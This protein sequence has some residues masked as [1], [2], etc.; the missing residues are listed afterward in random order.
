MKDYISKILIALLIITNFA[1]IGGVV[2]KKKHPQTTPLVEVKPD[3]VS[4]LTPP[5]EPPPQPKIEPKFESYPAIRNITNLGKVLSDI[6]GHMPAGHIYK[7]ND[8]I[9]WAHETTHGINSNIRQKFAS[10]YAD[11]TLYG[12]WRP[13][14]TGR[15]VFKSY[16]KINGFYVLEDRACVIQEPNTTIQAAAKLVPSSLRGGVYNLYM[17][18]QAASWGDTPLYVF[19][20]W[21]AYTNGAACRLD[22]GIKERS[23]TV[24]FALEFNVYALSVAMASKSE[25]E[26]F[27][28]YL[29]W[30]IERAM[31][32]YEDSKSLGGYE[33]QDAYLAKMRT[34]S[35]ADFL[36]K[37]T[38][39]YFGE[40]W[41]IKVLGI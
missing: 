22:L 41:A 23:E 13:L 1:L 6:E 7:D 25:D 34:S 35:D 24:L 5:K 38:K 26:Q 39:T 19:D 29:K 33:A 11:G 18:Q 14:H 31:K 21:T 40:E 32:L 2:Y 36:R 27:K 17:I 12:E 37:F 4:P 15:L 9:T 20:E 16:G 28:S 8:K 10:R 3:P 30:N